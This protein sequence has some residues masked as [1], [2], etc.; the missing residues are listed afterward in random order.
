MRVCNRVLTKLPWLHWCWGL[1]AIKVIRKKWNIKVCSFTGIEEHLVKKSWEMKI[2][3][4]VGQ[5]KLRFGLVPFS[6]EKVG[7]Y[8]LRVLS[9]EVITLVG[10]WLLILYLLL[11][12]SHL[13]KGCKLEKLTFCHSSCNMGFWLERF[14]RFVLDPEAKG[15]MCSHFYQP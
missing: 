4:T 8:E 15:W 3:S 10:S 5:L 9:L 13:H 6:C 7:V 14:S 2:L 11:T 12:S 1:G